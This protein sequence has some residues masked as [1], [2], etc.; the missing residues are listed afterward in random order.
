[1]KR[2]A[3]VFEDADLLVVEKPAGLLTIATA[4]E[5]RRTLYAQLYDHVKAK[6]PPERLFVVHRLDREASGLLVFA[7]SEASKRRLQDQFKHR[8]AGRIY[9]AL[10]EG[11]I[12]ADEETLRSRLAEGRTFK[13][14]STAARDRGKLAV[15]HLRVLRRLRHATLLEVRLESGR[16]HQ[17]RAHL[18]ERGHPIVGDARYGSRT[19]PLRRLALHATRLSFRHPRTGEPLVFHSRCPFAGRG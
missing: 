15:T 16:K 17:I 7:K 13:V 9:V 8:S 19:N 11:K 3:I 5:K 12:G 14:H 2:P 6:R 10:A 1:M 18:A 4:T